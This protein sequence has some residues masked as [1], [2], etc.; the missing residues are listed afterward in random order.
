MANDKNKDNEENESKNRRIS[1][2]RA[3]QNRRLSIRFGDI[4]G[5]RAGKD[6]RSNLIGRSG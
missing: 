4:L 3:E 1:V 6:R 5:R 2:R